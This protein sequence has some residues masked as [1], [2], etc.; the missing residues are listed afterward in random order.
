MLNYVKLKQIFNYLLYVNVDIRKYFKD[1]MRE[2]TKCNI[3]V[4]YWVPE[5]LWKII[6][7]YAGIYSIS[8]NH[9]LLNNI[10]QKDWQQFTR[11]YKIPLPPIIVTPNNYNWDCNMPKNILIG[12]MKK[13]LIGKYN[14]GP[15]RMNEERW[16]FLF[17]VSCDSSR[18]KVGDEIIV[19]NKEQA[20]YYN[21]SFYN[22]HAHTQTGIITKINKKTICF[23][24]Y[25]LGKIKICNETREI[26]IELDKSK[27]RSDSIKCD[28]RYARLYN[29]IANNVYN[30][31]Y[32]KKNVLYTRFNIFNHFKTYSVNNILTMDSF[33]LKINN[34]LDFIDRY[35]NKYIWINRK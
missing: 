20:H 32:M 13:W 28:V 30:Y 7:E 10:S 11:Q 24:P 8:T 31:S 17:S 35:N 33:Q 9:H 1:N 27:I 15:Y 18:F 25:C 3:P 19:Y 5:E 21:S 26:N 29:D 34:A 2:V 12:I 14:D 22:S 23:S 6:K 4:T 16:K